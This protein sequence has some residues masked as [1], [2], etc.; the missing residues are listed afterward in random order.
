MRRRIILA[1]LAA[2]VLSLLA[3]F[4]PRQKINVLLIT[5]DTTRADRLGCYG[6]TGARTPVL[7]ALAASG[8]L[9]ERVSTVAPMTLP[10][11]TSLFTGLY[12]AEHGVRTNGRTRLD[13]SIPTLAEVLTRHGYDTGAFVASFV[14]DARFGLARG[15]RTYDD[16]VS[17]HEAAADDQHRERNGASVVD[18]ALAWLGARRTAPFFCWVHLFDPHA[19]YLPHTDV[20]GD[21]FAGRPY[22]AEIAYVDRQIGRLVD[23]LKARG[24]DS[25][26]LVVV[27]GDHGEGLSEHGET[28]HGLMLYSATMHVPLIVTLR[29]RFAP[30][31]RVAANLS[32]VDVSPTLL[33]LLGLDDPRKATGKSFQG[34]LL[35]DAAHGSPCYGATE[36]PFLKGG[37]SPLRC[38]TEEN[39]KFIRTTRP[40]LYNLAEDPGELHNLIAAEPD[41]ARRMESRL[42]ELESQ[43]VARADV[44][45]RLTSAE[46]RK[47][48]SLGYLTSGP[49]ATAQ[50]LKGL[51]D[52]KDMLP[53]D[54]AID[55]AAEL[56]EHGEATSA[57]ERLRATIPQTP[58]HIKAH[59]NLAFALRQ[60]GEFDEAA[61]VLRSLLE[62]RPDAAEGHY[63]LALVLL[64]Q[65]RDDD[66]VAEFRKTLAA[67]P[68]FAEAHYDLAMVHVRRKETEEALAEFADTLEIDHRHGAAYAERANLLVTQGSIDDALADY[69]MAL[70]YMPDA[71]AL[72]HNL[73]FVLAGRGDVDGA[74]Q[75][76]ERA[77]ELSP[78]SAEFHYSL[79][80]LQ[81]ERG[82][83]NEAIR[84][85][86]KALE[87]K[88]DLTAARQR[89]RETQAAIEK[90]KP[91]GRVGGR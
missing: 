14:L 76:L 91:P 5:L 45:V 65:G 53:L 60:K 52:I 78:G 75:H 74:Q 4:W 85:L 1:G 81:M 86:T 62:V 83:Y 37:W 89:L 39:W 26:T 12:P 56:I 44:Q 32:P 9:C 13:N 80:A 55:E 24:L 27:I 31:R 28:R 67:D 8:V 40:E 68:G 63:G 66:A 46:R 22:D 38:L 79:G 42:A 57:I 88:P 48:E 35:G 7:D 11:H 16:E 47:L 59:W 10:T 19:P 64:Q 30:G 17:G 33:D 69:R 36:E 90:Q 23:F 29:D 82:N 18:A 51:P 84:H 2:T 20:F 72:H 6:Y 73:G 77:V 21:D 25:K 43:L 61:A 71:P 41:Q 15:F 70:K 49:A 54:V 87:I 50:N 3:W 34:A 58:G